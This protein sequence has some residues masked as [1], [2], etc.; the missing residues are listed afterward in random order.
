MVLWLILAFIFAAL[1]VMAVSRNSQRLEYI[2]KP[3]VLICLFPWL[4]SSTDLKG[5]ALWFGLGLVFSLVGDVLLIASE[6]LF[7][8][9][10]IAFLLAHISY[11]IGFL[12]EVMTITVWSLILAVIITISISRLLRR[13]V[14]AMQMKGQNSLVLPVST[15]A[16]VISLMLYTAISTLFNPLWKPSSAFFVSL[17]ALLFCISDAILAW[18][19]FV[20]PVNNGR[21]L[22]ITLYYL[23]Q[24]GL[25]AGVIS[26]FGK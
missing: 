11:I 3:A 21:V 6:R 15:Y 10:L 20:S 1:E 8:F 25:I 9:G 13:I 26:Q 23:G 19:K 22:N 24:M 5:N 4:Y 14:A 18:N 16:T 2:V 7:L 17:G 12:E